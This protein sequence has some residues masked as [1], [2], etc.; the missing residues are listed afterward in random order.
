MVISEGDGFTPS[1]FLYAAYS[2][3]II[4]ERVSDTLC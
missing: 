2:E 4:K 3:L 1:L